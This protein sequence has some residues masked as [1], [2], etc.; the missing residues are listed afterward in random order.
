[1]LDFSKPHRRRNPLTGEWIL[2]S[3][4]RTRRPWQGKVE[5]TPKLN[6]PVYDS[7]CYLCPGN[8]RDGGAGN[9]KYEK[10]FTFTNDHS[11]IL[12]GVSKDVYTPNDLI[13]AD[14][15]PG[16]CRVLCYC[17]EHNR[18]MADMTAKELCDVVAAWT[19][20][21]KTIGANDDISYVQIFEKAVF[22]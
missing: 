14:Q 19:N 6:Q 8:T 5:E 2:V 7:T 1:M 9:P 4:Q 16:M 20:E 12:P 15:E 10:T 21:Y 17:P 13:T 22:R 3:P 18:T 11:A